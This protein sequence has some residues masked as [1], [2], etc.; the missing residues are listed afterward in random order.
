MALDSQSETSITT[1]EIGHATS[2]L[3]GK[4]LWQCHRAADMAMFQFGRQR[5][6]QNDRGE[7]R[8]VGDVALHVQ[9]RW[10]VLRQGLIVIGSSDLYYPADFQVSGKVP[11]GFDWD[12]DNNLRDKLLD[13]LFSGN[14]REFLVRSISVGQAGSL[15]ILLSGDLSLELFPD[16]SL[17]GEHWRLF[18]PGGEGSHFVVSGSNTR[19]DL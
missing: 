8:E 12:K 9:C 18:T 1:L 2:V 15:Q 14:T 6:I 13:N 17:T 3:V 7:W 4:P 10:R 16:D 5:K 19:T 11:E